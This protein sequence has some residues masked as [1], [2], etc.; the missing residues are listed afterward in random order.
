MGR[1]ETNPEG[2]KAVAVTVPGSRSEDERCRRVAVILTFLII[3]SG[4]VTV[5]AYLM[6][7]DPEEDPYRQGIELGGQD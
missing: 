4:S 1:R 7:N 5:L 3:L 6:S 2:S